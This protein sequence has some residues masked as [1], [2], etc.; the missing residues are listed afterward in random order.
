M[1]IAL[2]S[3]FN[4]GIEKISLD[5]CSFDFSS[6]EYNGV[7]PFTTPVTLRGEIVNKAG[8]V[9]ISAVASFDFTAPCDRCAAKVK[10]HFDVPIEHGLVSELNNEDND[11]YIL[12]ENMQFNL[13]QLTLEDIY[14]YL[15][16]KFL[17]KEDCKGICS[18]CGTNLNETSC[19]CKKEID[20]RLE[21]LLSFLD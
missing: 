17:C 5:N 8:I 3:L 16:S 14:L 21:A 19:E 10:K 20:P 2:E 6:E 7:F 4:G 13:T 15:P 9:S 11:D 1:F 12:V 18:M